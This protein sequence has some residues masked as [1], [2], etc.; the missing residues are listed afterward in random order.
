M[1]HQDGTVRLWD[2]PSERPTRRARV[3]GTA[4]FFPGGFDR[5]SP[6]RSLSETE[7]RRHWDALAGADS[8]HAYEALW[9]LADAPEQAVP[10][11]ASH[12]RAAAAPKPGQLDRLIAD[13]DSDEF[14]ERE[15]AQRE[16]ERLGERAEPALRKASASSPSAEARRRIVPL[17][18]RLRGPV[19]DSSTLQGVR[20]VEVLEM[21]GN[22]EAIAVLRRLAEGASESRLTQEARASLTRLTS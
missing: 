3:P 4:P 22:T 16:L 20:A 1:G 13:L 2:V 11:L 21:I 10:F 5:H 18:E 17:L 19:S 9:A 14:A 7:L 6:S 12:L 8:A 15:K